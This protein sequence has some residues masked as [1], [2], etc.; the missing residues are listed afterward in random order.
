MDAFSGEVRRLEIALGVFAFIGLFASLALIA[1]ESWWVDQRFAAREGQPLA[2]DLVLV[3][4]DETYA[5]QFGYPTT[6]PKAYLARLV[7]ALVPYGPST[8]AFDVLVGPAEPDSLGLA[9]FVRAVAEAERRGVRI[10]LPARIGGYGASRVTGHG[11]RVVVT[12][13]PPLD[14]LTHSGYVDFQV[15][16]EPDNL[17]LQGLLSPAPAVR[18]L[19]L[20]ARLDLQRP[21]D[22]RNIAASFP[23]VAVVAHRGWLPSRAAAPATLSDAEASAVIDSLRLRIGPA[24]VGEQLA[25]INYATPAT[26]VSDQV[27]YFA[28]SDV[29]TPYEGELAQVRNR[30]VLI[31]AVFP[32][33]DGAD[34]AR[35]PFG[36]VRGGIVHLYA[37][38]TLLR[39]RYPRAL[40]SFFTLLLAGFVFFGV[41]LGWRW[42]VVPALGWSALVLFLYVIMGFSLFE[43]QDLL[44]P[45]AWP[46]WAGLLATALGFVFH[47]HLRS[48]KKV[49]PPSVSLPVHPPVPEAEHPALKPASARLSRTWW[50]ALGLLGLGIWVGR[51]RR[52]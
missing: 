47:R 29:L 33:P 34:V 46:V 1:P 18:E 48:R 23:L 51:G 5:E 32:S 4:L 35:T 3:G 40:G 19:P 11:L 13:P 45:M 49:R 7:D 44:L 24:F 17:P 16:L 38:D 31:A 39:G 22:A 36:N 21:G 15:T 28:A 27:R 8:I 14:T 50:M 20:L 30:L 43:Q 6:T 37:M 52:R 10:V 12:P 41:L 2:D 42:A 25:P 26:Q 9:A